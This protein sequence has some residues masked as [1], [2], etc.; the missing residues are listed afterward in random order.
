M[1]S[2]NTLQVLFLKQDAAYEMSSYGLRPHIRRPKKYGDATK[3]RSYMLA[4]KKNLDWWNEDEEACVQRRLDDRYRRNAAILPDLHVNFGDKA[5]GDICSK[6]DLTCESEPET[7]LLMIHGFTVS[8]YQNL[9]HLVVD[10]LL[11]SPSGKPYSYSLELGR[12]IKEHLFTELAYPMLEIF[13]SQETVNVVERFCLLRT[14][15]NI[16]MDC[17]GSVQ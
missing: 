17:N 9:Y 3:E 16:D 14:T 2:E 10:P 11:L 12:T 13:E 5:Q 6:S 15:P 7:G 1:P 4:P 8:E